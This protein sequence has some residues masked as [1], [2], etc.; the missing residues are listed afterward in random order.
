MLAVACSRSIG[1]PRSLLNEVFV[2]AAVTGELGRSLDPRAHQTAQ[3]DDREP[4]GC[5]KSGTTI[6]SAKIG[7]LLQL[8][9]VIEI[10]RA[11]AEV[12]AM[13]RG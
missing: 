1:A 8:N 2:T 5:D 11:D 6:G 4:V 9:N 12:V 13:L 3:H 10:E 7:V